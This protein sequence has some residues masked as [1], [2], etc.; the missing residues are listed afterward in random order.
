[1]ILS[2]G[3][4]GKG[5]IARVAGYL[6]REIGKRPEIEIAIVRAR[7]S[8][9]RLFKHPSV[10]FALASFWSK[11]RRGRFDVAHINVAPRGSTSRKRLYAAIAARFG[12]PVVLH[13]H[14]SGYNEYFESVGPARQAR[15]RSFFGSADAVVALS[16]FWRNWMIDAL[17]LDP[18]KVVEIPNGVPE[19]SGLVP[20][21]N[22][23]PR[24]VFL[25]E[26]GERKG[27]DMLLDALAD[28]RSRGLRFDAVLGGNGAIDEAQERARRL[29][30]ADAVSFPGWVG[31]VEV[32]ALLRQADI[33]T[34]PSRAE[35]QPVAILEAMARAV[36]VVSTHVG[37]IPEQ[38]VE[39][40]TGLLVPPGDAK[41]LADAIARLIAEPDTR[42]RMGDEGLARFK[43]HFSVESLSDRFAA[44]YRRLA[45]G[46]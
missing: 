46:G 15:I 18:A 20:P 19:A 38:V 34:L 10:P 44:L 23:V 7:L 17:K 24:I 41:Q 30:I 9:S 1:M 16:G 37:A 29:G 39:E 22:P 2:D 8:A 5:G 27:V 14:G 25:G 13:L 4:E 21:A 31:E 6:T 3:L 40:E 26:L 45:H 36:P 11:C 28:L 42:R 43:A 33:F 12:V 35:N 32:D